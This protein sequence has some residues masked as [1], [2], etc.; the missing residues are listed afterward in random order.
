MDRLELCRLRVANLGVSGWRLT[1]DLS[2][3][4]GRLR[5]SISSSSVRPAAQSRGVGRRPDLDRAG[6]PSFPQVRE[7]Y[8]AKANPPDD[9]AVRE[10]YKAVIRNEF[11]PDRGDG[12]A[13]LSVA[14]KAVADYAKV[15]GSA[16]GIADVMVYY[17]ETGVEFTVDF[18]DIDEPFYLSMERMYE[19]ALRHLAKHGL[20]LQFESRC[21]RIVNRT[22]GIGWGFHDTLRDLYEEY[23]DSDGT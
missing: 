20:W 17:V 1:S 16:N 18:G 22:S 12:K 2:G 10:K 5:T 6:E 14:R 7:Y 23:A 11:F 8:Q 3:P 13:R 15:A 9:S 21:S 4:G 19:A